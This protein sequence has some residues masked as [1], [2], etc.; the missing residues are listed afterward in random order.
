MLGVFRGYIEGLRYASAVSLTRRYPHTPLS[1]ADN[2][3]F[4]R[5]LIPAA[6]WNDDVISIVIRRRR[7]RTS[8][9]SGSASCQLKVVRG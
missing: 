3:N 4:G 7:A 1:S 2:N 6:R 9:A 5:V 8:A